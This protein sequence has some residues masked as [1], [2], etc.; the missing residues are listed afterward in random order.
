MVI[1][2]FS[3]YLNVGKGPP[4]D[5]SLGPQ[6][7]SILINRNDY[8]VPLP[9]VLRCVARD[10]SKM[11]VEILLGEKLCCESAGEERETVIQLKGT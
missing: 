8:R 5:N 1:Q 2:L 10:V 9:R 11:A 4:I 3:K 6:I 7:S